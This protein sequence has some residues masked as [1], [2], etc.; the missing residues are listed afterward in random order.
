MEIKKLMTKNAE[1]EVT[2]IILEQVRKNGMTISNLRRVTAKAI[3]YLESNATLELETEDS[4]NAES[5][6]TTNNK[7]IETKINDLSL[8]NRLSK[9]DV[10]D[11]IDVI[12]KSLNEEIRR[13]GST[14]ISV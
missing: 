2:N 12:V 8:A 5:I 10:K 3:G 13:S 9:K 7:E 14:L 1:E 11:A 6:I 4:D